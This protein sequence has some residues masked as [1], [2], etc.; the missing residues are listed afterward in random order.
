MTQQLDENNLLQLL[1]LA[2][3]AE[4]K[5]RKSSEGLAALAEEWQH[6]AEARREKAKN[7]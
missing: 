3:I 4:H 5:M 1:E 2:K 6:K 7:Q